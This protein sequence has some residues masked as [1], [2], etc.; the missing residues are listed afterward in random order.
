MRQTT[1]SLILIVFIQLIFGIAHGDIIESWKSQESGIIEAEKAKAIEQLEKA[2]GF[3]SI[4][5][6]LRKVIFEE[7][8]FVSYITLNLPRGDS[9]ASVK[10]I[11]NYRPGAFN[12][13]PVYRCHA[14]EMNSDVLSLLVQHGFVN[15]EE[16]S[17]PRKGR[18][19]KY[20]FLS[21]TAKII[22]YVVEGYKRS[23]INF[24]IDGFKIKLASKL[25]KSIDSKNENKALGTYVVTFSY[26][27]QKEFPY[28]EEIQ[29]IQPKKFPL[30]KKIYK[31]EAKAYLDPKTNLWALEKL[32]LP[33]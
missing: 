32:I 17:L 19:S 1:L 9:P 13:P 18:G 14:Y 30:I 28:Y 16:F 21:Y 2:I 23:S 8:K 12:L 3:N 25:L 5:E 31:G 33:K 29:R 20:T 7:S 11:K 27:L 15:L 10:R 24:G 22:P 4:P 6:P 26:T